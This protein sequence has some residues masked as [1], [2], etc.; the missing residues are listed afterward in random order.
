MDNF[1]SGLNV[2]VSSTA[3]SSS[4]RSKVALKPGHSLMDW[5]RYT[6]SGKDLSGAGGKLLQISPRELAKHNTRKDA[7]ISL[8]GKVYNITHY[9]DYHPG[10]E[11]ELMRGAGK[12]AT[13]LFNQVHRWVNAESMLQKC[14]V[15]VLKKS[16]SIDVPKLQYLKH[17]KKSK[18]VKTVSDSEEQNPVTVSDNICKETS[19]VSNSSCKDAFITPD[20][21]SP[22]V[23]DKEEDD[24]QRDIVDKSE[25]YICSCS[26][27][28]TSEVTLRFDEEEDTMKLQINCSY[29]KQEGLI[30]D[31]V[32]RKL[33]VKINY[34]PAQILNIEFSTN[35]KDSYEVEREGKN[36]LKIFLQA[37]NNVKKVTSDDMN[38]K[39]SESSCQ[40]IWW[41]LCE[42]ADKPIFW[43]CKLVKKV[44]LN[45]NTYLFTFLLPPGTKMWVPIGC[46]VHIKSYVEGVEVIRSY[47]P[48]VSS[49]AETNLCGDADGCKIVLMIKMYSLGVLTPIINQC[50]LGDIMWISCYDGS[51]SEE[52]LLNCNSLI[53]LA[54]GTG[55]TPMIRMI[56]WVTTAKDK[57]RSILLLFFNKTEEDIIWRE[58]LQNCAADYKEFQVIHILSES[59]EKWSGFSGKINNDLVEQL[60]T[61]KLSELNKRIFICGPLPFNETA[62]RCLENAGF[63]QDDIYVFSGS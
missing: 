29:L 19:I 47:T 28:D 41:N 9:L 35:Y 34:L 39:S 51:F 57:R 43:S 17:A 40:S 61:V 1:A 55:I 36:F 63:N 25:W 2:P 13:D 21:K 49:L 24:N 46:H 3:D 10:G 42:P 8:R 20:R 54:A 30:T 6:N 23:S 38:V 16:W 52:L 7:W 5:I 15:G 4:G 44:P 14:F 22:E 18:K 59:Y 27:S 26:K 37:L 32:N 11:D 60:L 33:F 50:S 58:E 56:K 12:D 48:V 53:M 45:Y 31:L 62:L